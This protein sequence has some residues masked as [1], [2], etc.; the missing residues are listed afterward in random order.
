MHFFIFLHIATVMT[1][2]AFSIGP[3]FLLRRVAD[4]GDVPAIRRSFAL[5][6]PLVRIIPALFG[7]GALLGIVA[8]FTNGYN[9]FEPWLLIA[10]VMFVLAAVVGARMTTPWFNRM[11]QGLRREPRDWAFRRIGGGHKRPCHAIGR[12]VRP[13]HR[14]GLHPG[15]GDLAVQLIGRAFN[16]S[17][18]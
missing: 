2:V 4:S 6:A 17:S 12:L 13:D 5:A 16:H 14:A 1:A 3:T 10:Y 18:M 11:V 9:P 8:I 15:H 7:V